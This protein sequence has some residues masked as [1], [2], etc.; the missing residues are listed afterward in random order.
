MFTTL[1]VMPSL[2]I[3]EFITYCGQNE[4]FVIT[5]YLWTRSG[6][7]RPRSCLLGRNAGDAFPVQKN[8]FG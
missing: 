5:T 4:Q 7:I 3:D 6:L 2:Q 8:M 1:T